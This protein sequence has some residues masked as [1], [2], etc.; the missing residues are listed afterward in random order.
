[1]SANSLENIQTKTSISLLLHPWTYIEGILGTDTAKTCSGMAERLKVSHDFLQKILD[2]GP[3][4][5]DELRK[6]LIALGCHHANSLCKAFLIVDDTLLVKEF[7]YVLEQLGLINPANSYDKQK[8]YKIVVMIWSNGNITIP[9]D[10]RIWIDGLGKTKVELAQEMIVENCK[11]I[12]FA[13]VLMDGLYPSDDM[14]KL[15]DNLSIKFIMRLPKNR[16]I[17]RSMRELEAKI[18][19]HWQYKLK[20]NTRIKR[21]EGFIQGVWRY[22]T[23]Y[24]QKNRKCE[25]ETRY[26][27]S[28]FKEKPQN[29]LACYIYRWSIEKF[30]RT[31]KQ[32]LGIQDCLSRSIGGQAN[33]IWAVFV[34][35]G[36]ADTIKLKKGYKTTDETIRLIRRKNQNMIDLKYLSG[37]I[38]SAL[39]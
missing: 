35:Y 2:A 4:T 38:F 6:L 36:I 33:H 18:G 10:F 7:S 13:M 31:V 12:P 17:R 23:A 29:I 15:L 24:K 37:A 34:A 1:M 20:G 19:D 26:L 21:F 8:G 5:A 14:L 39:A 25:Y 16:K 3:K 32:K 27:I 28:N 11:K 22:I 30:F 9:I